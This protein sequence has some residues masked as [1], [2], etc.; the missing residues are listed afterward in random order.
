MADGDCVDM[1][2]APRGA[3]GAALSLESVEAIVGG[4]PGVLFSTKDKT[5]RFVGGNDNMLKACGVKA[6]ADFLGRTSAE[7]FTPDACA[8]YDRQDRYVLETGR[9]VQDRLD[10]TTPLRGPS[11]WAL[12]SRWPIFESGM[13]TGIVVLARPL[14][15]SAKLHR[16]YRRVLDVVDHIE[17]N[18]DRE[19]EVAALAAMHGAPS[20]RLERD[21]LRI[22]AM[23]PGRYLTRLRMEAAIR[24]LCSDMHVAEVAQACGYADQSAFTRR[25]RAMMGVS[26]SEYRQLWCAG[27]A[28]LRD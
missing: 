19:H 14:A 15:N 28:W 25:F 18:I 20:K 23:P 7:F 10:F 27:G 9:P 24:L 12:L 3:G 2:D 5:L 17:A 13:L 4:I 8:R 16:I 1:R 11:V 22:F 6:R 26:P 21:F